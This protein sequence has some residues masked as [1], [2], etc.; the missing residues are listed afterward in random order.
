MGQSVLCVGNTVVKL[1][2]EGYQFHVFMLTR[3]GSSLVFKHYFVDNINP[4][5]AETEYSGSSG[6]ILQLLMP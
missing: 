2:F 5:G 3:V 6:S 4:A 1:E